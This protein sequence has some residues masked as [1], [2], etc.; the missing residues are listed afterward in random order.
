MITLKEYAER[1]NI[2]YEAVRKQI[3][4]YGEELKGHIHVKDRT[5][6]IDDKGV[7]I[8]DDIRGSN[9]IIITD[10]AKNDEL[11]QLK[12]EN[13]NLL[14]KIASLQEKIIEKQECISELQNEKTA[15]IQKQQ[16]ESEEK[17]NEIS[18]LIKQLVEIEQ[19]KKSK[20]WLHIFRREDT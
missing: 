2:S 4:K 7:Q 3:K 8:L 14:I 15:L 5:Q 12:E 16:S 10:K 6:Y 9:K 1:E 11:E 18:D 20:G 19:R 13:K 17:E